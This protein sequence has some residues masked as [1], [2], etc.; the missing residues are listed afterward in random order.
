M[1]LDV[2][3]RGLKKGF[4]VNANGQVAWLE[5]GPFF[6]GIG[7]ENG[8][9]NCGLHDKYCQWCDSLTKNYINRYK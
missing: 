1:R 9:Y 6:C 7:C 5:N 4:L 3:R 8:A 2:D